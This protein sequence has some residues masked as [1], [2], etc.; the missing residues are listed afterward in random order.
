MYSLD[1]STTSFYLT[2][3]ASSLEDHSLISSVQ[4]A[5]SI[6][7]ELSG[8]IA[9]ESHLILSFCLVAVGKPVVAKFADVT[10]RATAYI[11]VCEVFLNF[12]FAVATKGLEGSD[13]LRDWLALAIQHSI[14]LLTRNVVH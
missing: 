13:S 11:I 1:G 5:Q 3:A 7:R 12:C 14:I 2:F 4:V 10:S 6:I 9:A 8:E